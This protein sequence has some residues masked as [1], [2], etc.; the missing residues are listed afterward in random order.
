MINVYIYIYIL[1]R[2]L[3]LNALMAILM[4]DID[5]LYHNLGYSLLFN[6]ILLFS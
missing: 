6:L 3:Q 1:Y 4:R 5:Y 2:F